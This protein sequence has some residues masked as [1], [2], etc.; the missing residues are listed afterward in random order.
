MLNIYQADLTD[1]WELIAASIVTEHPNNAKTIASI[2]ITYIIP[3]IKKYI[4][5]TT[6]DT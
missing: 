5:K 4:T 1:A 2:Y 3:E 6:L